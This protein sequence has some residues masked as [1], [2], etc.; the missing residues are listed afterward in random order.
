MDAQNPSAPAHAQS[1]VVAN[2]HPNRRCESGVGGLIHD[3]ARHTSHF[4]V[5]GNHLAQHPKLSGLAIGLGVYIQS[6]PAGARVD[7]KTLTA[8]FPEGATRIAAALRELE[9]YGYLRRERQRV[10][11]GRIVTRTISCNQP[12]RRTDNHVPK[13]A[14]PK[15]APPKA[16][17][18]LPRPACPSPAL[19]QQATDLLADLR[20]HDSRLLLSARDTAH[21]APGVAAWLERDVTPTAVRHALTTGLPDEPLCRPAALLAHRLTEQLPPPPPL[22]TPAPPPTVRH[23]L[24]NCEGCDRAF[25]SPEPGRCLDYRSGLPEA[26]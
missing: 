12:G 18:P 4:T 5:V 15:K 8:R 25:R 22:R 2:N 17:P 20:R 23:P 16:L 13:P 9:T 6:L 1:R 14:R 10:P 26:A 7:I 21:L 19:I 3:N 11:G 24:R